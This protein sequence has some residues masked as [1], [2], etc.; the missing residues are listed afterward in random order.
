MKKTG[1]E[2]ARLKKKK[3]K[4]K[5]I[6]YFLCPFATPRQPPRLLPYYF[7][8]YIFLTATSRTTWSLNSS[9][10][11]TMQQSPGLSL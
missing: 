5:S 4:K 1:R 10:A 6:T 9:P 3:K 7:H 8:N 2:D 11:R